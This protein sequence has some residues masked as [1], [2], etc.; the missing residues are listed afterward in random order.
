MMAIAP[1]GTLIG[2][3]LHNGSATMGTVANGIDFSKYTF[4]G[5]F[6]KSAGFSVDGSGNIAATNLFSSTTNAITSGGISALAN[7]FNTNSTAG[8]TAFGYQTLENATSSVL[9][10]AVGYQALKGNATISSTGS[11]Q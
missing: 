8:E 5:N 11:N 9:D 7:Y 6:L 1:A 4:T 10:T 2:T 3:T